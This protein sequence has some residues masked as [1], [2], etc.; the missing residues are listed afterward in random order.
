MAMLSLYTPSNVGLFLEPY[1]FRADSRFAPSQWEP[2]LQ[3]NAISHWLGTKLESA[4]CVILLQ[5]SLLNT[6]KREAGNNSILNIFIQ[7][8]FI[9][10]V[11]LFSFITTNLTDSNKVCS[12]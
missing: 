1:V 11:P 7:T 12:H 9:K 3:S 5:V 10:K 6:L 4:L 8:F 2:L